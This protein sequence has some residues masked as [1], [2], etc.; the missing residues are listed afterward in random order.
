MHSALHGLVQKASIFEIS[1]CY[2]IRTFVCLF[3]M[4]PIIWIGNPLYYNNYEIPAH[5][6]LPGGLCPC[7]ELRAMSRH[8]CISGY[9]GQKVVC[10]VVVVN[11]AAVMLQSGG[12]YEP[13][14]AHGNI[15]SGN[16]LENLPANANVR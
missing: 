5:Q 9:V 1:F 14:Y 10:T 16:L 7:F 6:H 13:L 8:F 3:N 11:T 15:V 2:A 4:R 12:H